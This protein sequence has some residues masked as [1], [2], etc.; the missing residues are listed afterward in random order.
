MRIQSNRQETGTFQIKMNQNEK[1]SGAPKDSKNIRASDLNMIP[2]AIADK[3]EAAKE[4]AARLLMDQFKKDGKIDQNLSQ[5]REKITKAR[6][7]YNSAVKELED[8]QKTQNQWMEEYKVS[9]DSVEHQSLELLR[10]AKAAKTEGSGVTLTAEEQERVDQLGEP[11]EYQ[12]KM[13]GLLD[14]KDKVLKQKDDAFTTVEKETDRLKTIKQ[15]LLKQDPMQDAQKSAKK[16]LEASTKEMLDLLVDEAKEK[17]EEDIEK[18]KE[19]EKETVRVERDIQEI[20]IKQETKNQT[21]KKLVA[22]EEEDPEDPTADKD[23][24][25]KLNDIFN[26]AQSDTG[27]VVDDIKG[28]LIDDIL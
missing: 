13:M 25:N 28:V 12:E 10:K 1:N 23:F 22:E 26:K 15:E 14:Y 3:K 9:E 17:I 27:L 16:V 18:Q 6:E 5:R 20:Q 4:K 7:D 19:K 2:D 11:T 21:A 8:I 24:Y